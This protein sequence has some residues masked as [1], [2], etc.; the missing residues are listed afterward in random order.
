MTPHPPSGADR[1][2]G[3][4]PIQTD[5]VASRGGPGALVTRATKSPAAVDLDEVF[6]TL[7]DDEG[8]T[9]QGGATALVAVADGAPERLADRSDR[10]ASL[11]RSSGA[12]VREAVLLA[13]RDAARSENRGL[14]ALLEPLRALLGGQDRNEAKMT[15]EALAALLDADSDALRGVVDGA[16][17]RL[18]ARGDS[19]RGEN[20]RVLASL[21][22]AFPGAVVGRL[23]PLLVS[24]DPPVVAN[25]TRVLALIAETDPT[26]VERVVP[27]ATNMLS[28]GDERTVPYA[29]ELLEPV[30]EADPTALAGTVD[31]LAGLLGADRPATRRGAARILASV[32][33]QD[34]DAVESIVP[35]VVDGLSDPDRIVRR[36]A[37]YVLGVVR[38]E[39]ARDPL[40]TARAD[41][42][43]ELAAVI[44]RALARLDG[45][46]REPPLQ[47]VPPGDV[48]RHRNGSADENQSPEEREAVRRRRLE[49]GRDDAAE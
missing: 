25:A 40:E 45:E 20:V 48:F 5:E 27:E 22:A 41:A 19:E 10:L 4:G 13:V 42:S 16:A 30:A 37:A 17:E 28:T 2:D 43:P 44:D 12:V 23:R 21:G 36:D 29:V 11:L 15:G 26:A 32:A 33:R 1:E 7:R 47:H 9:R 38:A 49:T 39:S 14:R 35:A 8:E 18:Q 3:Q 24:S 46:S 6:E 34:P 31:S